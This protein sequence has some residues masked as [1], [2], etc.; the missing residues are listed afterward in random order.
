MNASLC[1]LA[2]GGWFPALLASLL[3]LIALQFTGPFWPPVWPDEAL[4]SS[5]AA[6]LATDGVFATRVLAGLIPGM[7]QATLWNA[8]LYMTLLAG[9]YVF[10]GE[11]LAVGRGLSC[12]LAIAALFVYSQ[13]L[14]D[15]LR[16]PWVRWFALFAVALDPLFLRSAN[17][18]RMDMLT[19]LLSL[20]CVFWALRSVR[21]AEDRATLRL[22]QRYAFAAGIAMGA[23]GMSHPIAVLLVPVVLICL[24][25]SWRRV[26]SAVVGAILGIGPWLIYIAA[27][28][29]LFQVQ[30]LSQLR[31]KQDIVEL[32]GGDTGGVF[33]VY[34]AQYSL[35]KPGM[36]LVALLI[37]LVLLLAAYQA[38]RDLKT[39]ADSLPLWRSAILRPS[40]FVRIS[41]LTATI[42]LITLFASEMWYPLQFNAY[43]ILLAALLFESGGFYRLPFA[44]AAALFPALSAYYV[45]H[46]TI[47]GLPEAYQQRLDDFGAAVQGCRRVYLRVRPDPYFRLR[48]T[49]AGT[50]VLEFVPGKLQFGRD[51]KTGAAAGEFLQ[52][53]YQTIDCYLLDANDSWEPLLSAYLNQRRAEF[54][55]ERLPDRRH[56][57]PAFVW[58]RSTP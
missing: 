49:N 38:L 37:G 55:I 1:R 23:A 56:L 32:A 46:A 29:S 48:Q 31:R 43:L 20:L 16:S 9:L 10:T 28:H 8:P 42:F 57:E 27:N 5:P 35:R 36:V 19:L 3:L 41:L 45:W 4:F 12:A 13:L 24:W 26:A 34:L 18:T 39:G 15:Q 6:A 40:A 17:T 54:Q 52:R 47:R 7:E 2:S 11:E 58:R 22:S 14:R 30:F 25:P 21:A 51:P 44:L 33:V 53:R 50:E